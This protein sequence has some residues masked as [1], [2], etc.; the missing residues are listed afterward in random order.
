M[1]QRELFLANDRR[2]PLHDFSRTR[3]AWWASSLASWLCSRGMCSIE[4]ST[5]AIVQHRGSSGWHTGK[6]RSPATLHLR[7]SVYA[8][9]KRAFAHVSLSLEMLNPLGYWREIPSA[10]IEGQ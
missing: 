2:L 6:S 5:A 10:L 1:K 9:Q 4:K 3:A 7:P 8:G